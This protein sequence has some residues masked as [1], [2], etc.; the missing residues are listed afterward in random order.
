MILVDTS[1]WVDHFRLGKTGLAELLQHGRVT[2]HP[3]I[4]GEVA[5]GHLKQRDFILTAMGHLPAAAVATDSEVLHF[6]HTAALFGR[7]IGYIDAHLLASVRLSPGTSL[8]TRDKRLQNVADQLGL[9]AVGV[10]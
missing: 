9:K 8:W 4:I 6:I 1:V 10:H 7:G 5:L 3:F 2:M